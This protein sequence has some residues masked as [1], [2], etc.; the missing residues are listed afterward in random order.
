MDAFNVTGKHAGVPRALGPGHTRI[1]EPSDRRI[2]TKHT[3]RPPV[4]VVD[5]ARLARLLINEEEEGVADHHHL[6]QGLIHAHR[7]S[8]VHLLAHNNGRVTPLLLASLSNLEILGA[9]QRL[10]SLRLGR[11]LLLNN[12]CYVKYFGF[13]QITRVPAAVVFHAIT[14]A[15]QTLVKL[16]G[17]NVNSRVAVGGAAPPRG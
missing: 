1:S 3:V 10:G 5:D 15:A 2:Q 8:L 4:T 9:T 12:R 17:G 16:P 6:V 7:R 14:Q 13:D 11:H